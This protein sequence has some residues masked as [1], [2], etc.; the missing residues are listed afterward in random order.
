MSPVVSVVELHT[1]I[2]IHS[3]LLLPTAPLIYITLYSRPPPLVLS[4]YLN[5]AGWEEQTLEDHDR[6]TEEGRERGGRPRH[7]HT[8]EL[9]G[10][11]CKESKAE[12]KEE[13]E[14]LV[15]A[16]LPHLLPPT[17]HLPPPTSH[18]PLISSIPRSVLQQL[19]SIN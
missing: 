1:I 15:Y 17:S 19:L 14:Q 6:H 8:A 9:L 2:N 7:T 18:L 4:S 5:V 13:Q 12:I 11:D 3:S 10:V 16:V